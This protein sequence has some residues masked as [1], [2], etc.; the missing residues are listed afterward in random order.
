ME[1]RSSKKG[2]PSVGDLSKAMAKDGWDPE[3]PS[4]ECRAELARPPFQEPARLQ[5]FDVF[6]LHVEINFLK[7]CQ[8]YL[9]G[10]LG[11]ESWNTQTYLWKCAIWFVI[12]HSPVTIVGVLDEARVRRLL[13]D[14]DEWHDKRLLPASAELCEAMR[15]GDFR[16][17]LEDYEPALSN[18]AHDR[19][20]GLCD[21]ERDVRNMRKGHAM[22]LTQELSAKPERAAQ[23]VPPHSM[24]DWYLI[25]G[26]AEELCHFDDERKLSI[27]PLCVKSSLDKQL[28]KP[29]ER[30]DTTPLDETTHPTCTRAP[31]ENINIADATA[32]F[33]NA[34][35]ALP[36]GTSNVIERVMASRAAIDAARFLDGI[37]AASAHPHPGKQAALLREALGGNVSRKDIASLFELSE[38]QVRVAEGRVLSALKKSK[39]KGKSEV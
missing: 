38:K 10:P 16:K 17:P 14:L 4:D 39:K 2:I 9:R 12:R 1:S 3:N 15:T 37:E 20:L 11:E 8:R 7:L 23:E 18:L 27:R 26:Q 6:A 28:G 34:L 21:F 13:A 30:H 36:A 19:S 32:R 25:L 35:K 33:D 5:P 22:H 31:D 29:P 24:L